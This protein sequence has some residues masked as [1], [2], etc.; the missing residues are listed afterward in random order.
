MSSARGLTVLK[1]AFKDEETPN[2]HTP[3]EF[4]VQR[5]DSASKAG[6]HMRLE[7]VDDKPGKAEAWSPT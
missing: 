3:D 5:E 6:G 7:L 1:M 4:S 2:G